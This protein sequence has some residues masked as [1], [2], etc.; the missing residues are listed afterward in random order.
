M[1]EGERAWVRYQ[2]RLCDGAATQC[3]RS[4]SRDCA[5]EVRSGE[6]WT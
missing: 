5:E 6:S 2:L 4:I 1:L 3:K